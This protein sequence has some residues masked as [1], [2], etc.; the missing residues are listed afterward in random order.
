MHRYSLGTDWLS[1]SSAE[2]DL[3]VTVDNKLNMSQQCAL[4][5]KANDVLGC[6]DRSVLC[7]PEWLLHRGRCYY[8]SEEKRIWESSRDYCAA[9]KSNLLVFENEDELASIAALYSHYF[10][11]IPRALSVPRGMM[12]IFDGCHSSYKWICKKKATL[13]DF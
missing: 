7:P 13:L 1:S 11:L 12:L 4:V 9:R 2:K 8:F 10:P 6:I 5:R 3:G